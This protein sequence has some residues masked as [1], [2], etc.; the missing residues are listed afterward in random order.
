M[1]I[2]A[3]DLIKKSRYILVVTHIN[4]DADTICSALA[5]SNYF[6]EN[7]IKYS[8]YNKSKY[9]MK[10]LD[11]LGNYSKI[12][13]Q[14]PKFYDLIITLDCANIK[15]TGLVFNEGIPIINIDHHVSNDNF[16]TIN[17]V[18]EKKA[19][20]AEIVFSLFEKN[21]MKISKQTAECL[22]VG[23]YDDS[24]AFSSS[25]CDDDIFL[26]MNKLVS[27]GA[28]PSY[29]SSM[30]LHRDSLAKYR[31]IPLVLDSLELSFSGE[32][33]IVCLKHEW[34]IQTGGS[35]ADCTE[36]L[37]MILKIK[38]LNV[39]V[40]LSPTKNQT[41]KISLRSKRDKKAL[42]IASYFD[43]GG[44]NTSAAC[45]INLSN[46][47]AVKQKILK[48]IKKRYYDAT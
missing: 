14:I 31:L 1:Y 45:V 4:H 32:V 39:A 21:K 41:T 38:I 13:D 42:E 29:I 16:G 46:T 3:L 48:Y 11:F 36:A 8:L 19:S 40:L 2:E 44:H 10:K 30:F 5:I 15:R 9:I 43:G 28:V 6:K 17:L 7:K 33:G 20:T 27:F 24:R 26:T 25:R 12:S 23:I 22:Y 34:L 35:H 18:N 37:D 47:D